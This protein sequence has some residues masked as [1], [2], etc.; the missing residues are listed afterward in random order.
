MRVERVW[1]E[2]F[3]NLREFTVDF[4]ASHAI[5]TIVG[6]NGAGKSNLIEALAIIFRDLDAMTATAFAYNIRFHIRGDVVEVE[7][8]PERRQARQVRVNGERS[9]LSKLHD[10]VGG[11]RRLPDF[12][13][14]YYSGPTNRLKRHFDRHQAAFNRSLRDGEELPLRRLF[15]AK[16]EHSQFVLLAFFLAADQ[17]L[18]ARF[19]RDTLRIEGFDSAIF[20]IGQPEWK[21]KG[22]DERFWNARGAVA[23]LLERLLDLSLAELRLNVPSSGGDGSRRSREQVY[24]YLPSLESL[25]GLSEAYNGS[26][27]ELFA[28]FESI[29]AAELLADLRVRVRAR[30]MDGSLTFRELSEGEQQLLV[31]L[32]LLRF[33]KESESLFLLDEPDTHLNPAWS[34]YYTEM[35][36]E[37]SGNGL[38]SGQIL[39]ASHDPLVVAGL[40]AAQVVMLRRDDDSGH[41]VAQ[42]P[43]NDPRGMGVAG[44]LTSEI[45]GLASDLDPITFAKV[46]RRRWLASADWEDL[47]GVERA[48]LRKLTADLELLDFAFTTRDPL[49]TEFERAMAQRSDS[50]RQVLLPDQVAAR[51]ETAGEVLSQLLDDPDTQGTPNALH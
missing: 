41:V 2:R 25:R 51:R 27:Q 21:A 16:P 8:R 39:M 4:D 17:E 36:L 18:A 32:G 3:K 49:Y 23:S 26:P 31:V 50:S 34:I 9:S 24:L 1:I 15:Y 38:D 13:F 6:R 14:G 30:G 33:T 43:E 29:L 35:L 48:E 7:N 12:V 44:L 42:T 40:V 20:A 5:T 11:I 47:N 19:L 45:Y 46:Q 22:G 10:D 28:A 37:H